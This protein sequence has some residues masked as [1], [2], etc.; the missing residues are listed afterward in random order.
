MAD[1]RIDYDGLEKQIA[2]INTISASYE[3]AN[4]RLEMLKEKIIS[5]WEG[6]ASNAFAEMMQK[7]IIQSNKMEEILNVLKG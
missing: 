6:S 1:I 5:G 3:A 2:A 7:Y 4:K